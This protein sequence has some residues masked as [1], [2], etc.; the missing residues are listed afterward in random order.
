MKNP[1]R[2]QRIKYCSLLQQEY[3]GDRILI[4]DANIDAKYKTLVNTAKIKACAIYV[5]VVK[6]FT[7]EENNNYDNGVIRQF[8]FKSGKPLSKRIL[9]YIEDL[10]TQ[11]QYN[12]QAIQWEHE[13][14][15]FGTVMVRPAF[16]ERTGL[17]H[18]IRLIPAD[19]TLQVKVDEKFS[20]EAAEIS[21]ITGDKNNKIEHV[22][23][24]TF[25]RAYELGKSDRRAQSS[26]ILVEDEHKF[27]ETDASTIGG[28]P[29]TTLRYTIDSRLFWGPFDGGLASL[30]MLRSF[31]LAD[32]VHRTQVSL[33][34]IL[35]MA[36]YNE[37]EAISAVQSMASGKVMRAD[38]GVK[39]EHGE[40]YD[41]DPHYISPQGMEPAKVLAIFMQLYEFIRQTRGHSKKNFEVG[42]KVQSFEAQRLA[43]NVLKR[44]Q[45]QNR[46]FLLTVEQ[47]NLKLL[48]H[49]NNKVTGNLTLPEDI[50]VIL[51][52]VDSTRFSNMKE[53]QEFATVAVQ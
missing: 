28:M 19:P 47:R 46:P 14:A 4:D 45:L 18:W 53:L 52:W 31:L 2:E 49:E 10:Y 36:G 35:V 11:S 39:G 20:N 21:Y 26:K 12:L 30:S 15:L 41:Q 38:K 48:I 9:Q 42:A 16:D 37:E 5:P 17:L 13:A 44:K 51:D 33:F 29:W 23:D 32:S 43:D 27:K 34:E 8:R 7:D 24:R 25:Y 6:A 40:P 3:R 50:E 1:D 22:W